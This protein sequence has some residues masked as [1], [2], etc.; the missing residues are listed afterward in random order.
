MTPEISTLTPGIIAISGAIVLFVLA[1]AGSAFGT[2]IAAS[3]ACGAWKKCFAHNRP[4]PFTMVTFVGMPLTNTLYGMV[5]MLN[6]IAKVNDNTLEKINAGNSWAF[7]AVCLVV[8]IV[9]ALASWLQARAAACACDAQ[10]E[11]GQGFGNYIA[12][13]GIIEAVTIFI[14]VFSLVVVGEFFPEII[15]AV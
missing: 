1:S 13:I 10:G 7:L 15:E 3:A 11:T 6:I 4:A 9:M 8:G 2:G 5:L 14:F 12:A